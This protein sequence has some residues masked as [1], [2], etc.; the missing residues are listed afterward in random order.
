[1]DFTLA[2][3]NGLNQAEAN[4]SVPAVD[5]GRTF[6]KAPADADAVPGGGRRTLHGAVIQAL[7]KWQDH[8][9]GLESAPTNID[10][11]QAT[12]QGIPVAVVLGRQASHEVSDQAMAFLLAFSRRLL[13]PW[14]K[15]RPQGS[16]EGFRKARRFFGGQGENV[17]G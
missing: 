2:G 10:V 7:G 9:A 14:S 6:A 12:R 4:W 15:A 17:P 16:L 1:M 13:F 3:E 11:K 5:G 8:K